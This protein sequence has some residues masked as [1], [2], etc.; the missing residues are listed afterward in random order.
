[1]AKGK[2]LRIFISI[3]FTDRTEDDILKEFE[4]IRH[5][6]SKKIPGRWVRA[7]ASFINYDPPEGVTVSPLWYLGKSIELMA[8]ADLVVFSKDWKSARGCQAEHFCAE[9]YGMNIMELTD[10]D[11]NRN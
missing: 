6:T 1:M 4:L 3:P 7:I 9:K 2:T 11:Y 5:I 10:E 8:S